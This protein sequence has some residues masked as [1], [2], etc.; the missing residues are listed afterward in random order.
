MLLLWKF[1]TL[2][3]ALCSF[4]Y[5]ELGSLCLFLPLDS[6]MPLGAGC[7]PPAGGVAAITVPLLLNERMRLGAIVLLCCCTCPWPRCS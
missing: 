7:G 4:V 6:G 5:L 3:C 2:L 1:A